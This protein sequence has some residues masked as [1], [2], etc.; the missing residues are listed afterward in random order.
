MPE[1]R[2]APQLCRLKKQQ[3]QALEGEADALRVVGSMPSVESGS[4][5]GGSGGGDDKACEVC[6]A[7][8]WI[9]GG[10]WIVLCDRCGSAQ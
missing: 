4:C 1:R 5:G 2:R 10:N 6:A 9:Y 3:I 8:S 7:A